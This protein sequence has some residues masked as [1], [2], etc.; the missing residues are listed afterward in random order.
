LAATQKIET[1]YFSVQV[2]PGLFVG[3]DRQ[4]RRL[5][6]QPSL[7]KAPAYFTI[8]VFDGVDLPKWSD[9]AEVRATSEEIVT[10]HDCRIATEDFHERRLAAQLKD[11]YV[12]IRYGYSSPG[13]KFAPSLERMTQ[14]V[15]VRM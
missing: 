2:E 15:R 1:P 7:T 4:G 11:S 3:V 10:W 9:C 12:L 14:S 5:R 6:V 8:E 13:T